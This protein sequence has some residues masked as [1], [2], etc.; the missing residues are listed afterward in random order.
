MS[1]PIQIRPLTERDL[2]AFKALRLEALRTEPTS[3][4]SSYEE[5]LTRPDSF[6]LQSLIGTFPN[7]TFGAFDGDTLVGM[8]GFVVFAGLKQRHKGDMWG[9]YVVPEMRRQGLAERLVRAVVEHARE[10]VEILLSGVVTANANASNLY[11]R[12]GFKT[13]GVERRGMKVDGRYY[14]EELIALE[15]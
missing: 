15:F 2:A 4:S 5:N 14:D 9:V 11:K 10:H 3:F 6:F 1:Q 7:R 12:L 13:Y 8:A